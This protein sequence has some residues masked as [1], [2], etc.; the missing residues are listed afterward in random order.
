MSIREIVLLGDPVLRRPAEDVTSFDD[1]LR[2][3]VRDLFE[4]MY[5]AEGIGLAAP[6]VGVSK[7]VMVVDLRR[8]DEPSARV[9][10]VN[11]TVT[12]ESDEVEKEA[13]G[14]LSIP[15]IE[16]LVIRPW[17][18]KVE[19]V[20]PRGRPVVIEADELFARALQHE[21]DHLDGILIL[22]R[23]S[24]LKRRMALKKWKK[25]QEDGA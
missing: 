4:T 1:G 2:A 17:A 16:D 5:H 13:E 25:L 3:L 10:M 12:W 19:G 22:D 23:L 14:C 11:P 15:G 20:D 8:E 18:V 9:A 6:Q 24:P 7:R 21:V